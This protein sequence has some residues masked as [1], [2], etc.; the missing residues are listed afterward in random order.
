MAT[1]QQTAFVREAWSKALKS[2][3]VLL[4]LINTTLPQKDVHYF[5][6]QA[7]VDC[8]AAY[9]ALNTVATVENALSAEWTRMVVDE[10][11]VGCCTSVRR[12]CIGCVHCES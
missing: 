10:M 7:E 6:P 4:G 8:G 5:I 1:T 9:F 2:L 11:Q 3:K 12:G